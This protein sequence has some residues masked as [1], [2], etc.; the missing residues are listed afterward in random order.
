MFQIKNPPCVFTGI[1]L[2]FYWGQIWRRPFFIEIFPITSRLQIIALCCIRKV[3][4]STF[5]LFFFQPKFWNIPAGFMGEFKRLAAKNL[6][7]ILRGFASLLVNPGWKRGRAPNVM[8]L[9]IYDVRSLLWQTHLDW[10]KG[11]NLKM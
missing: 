3:V 7:K 4:F 10:L 11:M 2:W 8:Q 9:V 5:N 1:G 6:W